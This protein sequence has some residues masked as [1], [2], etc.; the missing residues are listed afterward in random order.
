MRPVTKRLIRAEATTAQ[1]HGVGFFDDGAGFVS[2]DD[3]ARNLVGAVGEGRDGDIVFAH[4][5]SLSVIT[6]R[7]AYKAP[8]LVRKLKAQ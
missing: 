5:C 3:A 4:G 6:C 7:A 1:E 2:Y 8:F